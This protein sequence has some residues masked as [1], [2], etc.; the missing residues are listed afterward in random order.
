MKF[1]HL[2]LFFLFSCFLPLHAQE[3]DST[4]KWSY[5]PETERVYRVRHVVEGLSSVAGLGLTTFMFQR[6]NDKD[7]VDISDLRREDVPGIDR[8][9]F[10]NDPGVRNSAAESS[11]YV[12]NGS[13]LLPFT[14]FFDKRIRKDWL[15]VT[16]LYLEAQ[17]VNG[18]VY[19]A[20]PL[21]PNFHNRVRPLAYYDEL[22]DGERRDRG[23]K[24]SFFSGHVSTVATGTFFFAKV[25]TDY[26]PEWRGRQRALIYGL[27]SLPPAY[28]A[29]QRVRALK[30]FP[31]D[32]VVGFGVG[33]AVGILTPHIHKRWQ[34][35][36]R[37]SLT[38]GGS[39]GSGAG[40]VG[41]GLTF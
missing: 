6:I 18:L 22:S 35:N 3:S 17:S 25:L 9:A 30:H 40:G 19:A 5:D 1:L 33:A 41:I 24:N 15:D 23:N 16:L 39:F 29:I 11:D 12:F 36:H 4:G 38:V 32:T 26:H 13:I 34:R 37:S 8:W 28:V 14:L 20:S 31:T 10:P 2:P 21:G 27:A 7:G